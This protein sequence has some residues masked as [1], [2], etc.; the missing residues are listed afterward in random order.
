[1]TIS[2]S[3]KIF[4]DS[5]VF[6]AFTDR[7]DANHQKSVQIL[8]GLARSGWHLFTSAPNIIET[9]AALSHNV[10]FSVALEFLEAILQSDIEVLYPQRADFISAFRVL[11][12]N[13]NH[14]IGLREALNAAMMQK[15]E[16]AQVA[17]FTY[18]HNLFGTQVSSLV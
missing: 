4:I 16:I 8:E 11:K 5:T 12:A 3:R 18:W 13:R 2:K 10:G 9:Y 1:M 17:V 14:Q 6:F 7:S 15:R